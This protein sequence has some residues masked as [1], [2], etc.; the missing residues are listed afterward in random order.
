M[1]LII[2]FNTLIGL[3]YGRFLIKLIINK[4]LNKFIK[5]RQIFINSLRREYG[6]LGQA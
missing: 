2:D 3:P 6:I 4:S 1:N 5:K